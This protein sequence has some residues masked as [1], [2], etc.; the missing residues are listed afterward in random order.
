MKVDA[1]FHGHI[2]PD[3]FGEELV[4]LAKYYNY[5]YIGVENNNHGLTT[6]KAI[7]RKD[8][9]NIYFSKTYDQITD[10]LTQKIGW[11]TNA[12]TKWENF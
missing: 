6:L 12:K 3:L 11:S 10:K 4:K 1:M 7:Q 2:D 9:Y 8:Y 5:A